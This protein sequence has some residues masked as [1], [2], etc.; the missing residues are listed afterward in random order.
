MQFCSKCDNLYYKKLDTG[1][2]NVLVNYCRNCGHIDEL[3][4]EGVCVLNTQLKQNEQKFNDIVNEYTI[5]DPTLP[6]INTMKCPN[7]ECK[8]NTDTSAGP[9]EIMYMRYD[10]DNLKYM[11]ICTACNT[12]WKTDDAK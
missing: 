3:M 8:T 12:A 2:A 4:S 9:P 10:G 7:A 5:L 11:Y 1:N 6:V